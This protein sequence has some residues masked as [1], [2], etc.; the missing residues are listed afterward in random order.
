MKLAQLSLR[1]LFL[2]VVIAAMGGG[3]I[4]SRSA[5]SSTYPGSTWLIGPNNLARS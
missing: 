3:W 5:R 4:I 2:L 1:D